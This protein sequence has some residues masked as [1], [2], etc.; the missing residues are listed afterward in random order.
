V[1]GAGTSV[2]GARRVSARRQ[3]PYRQDRHASGVVA[4]LRPG[5][6]NITD[7]NRP[8]GEMDWHLSG[9]DLANVHALRHQIRAYLIRHAE[10][11]TD[12]ADAELIVQELCSS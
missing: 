3:V 4:L 6:D 12:V 5:G 2:S 11:E 9:D 7:T 1:S 8:E 10:P